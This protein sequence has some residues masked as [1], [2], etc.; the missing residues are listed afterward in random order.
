MEYNITLFKAHDDK[1]R[2]LE[3]VTY[4]ITLYDHFITVR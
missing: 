4:K 1:L 3:S 2:V